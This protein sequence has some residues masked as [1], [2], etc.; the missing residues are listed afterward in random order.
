MPET[1]LLKPFRDRV[2]S[3]YALMEAMITQASIH[4]RELLKAR[5]QNITAD[6]AKDR[7]SLSW[8]VDSSRWDMLR[9]KGY[10]THYKTSEVTG[11]PRMYYDHSRPFEKDVRFYDYFTP[12]DL[13]QS[14]EAYVI[15]QGW[16][17]VIDLLALNGVKMKRLT[18]D[19]TISVEACR[20]ENYQSYPQAYEKHHKNTDV[21]ISVSTTRLPFLKGD[22]WIPTSQ[23]CR[24][25][26]TE[27]LEP[28]G[29]DSYFAW[30]FFDA[31]LEE[32]EGYSTYRWEDIAAAWLKQHPEIR[33]SLEKRKLSD[34]SFL[35]NADAQ[36]YFVYRHTP[37]YEPAHLRY[38]VF[39]VIQ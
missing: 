9:F 13:I 24:R 6:E 28:T 4:A 27:M 38:P 18:K 33:D 7:W 31:I 16:H 1:H 34:T 17:E 29:A 39:R 35:H 2:L 22:Y 11:L 12:G 20:I 5:Q 37:Y 32:K 26:I 10:Q 25:F 30:N 21:K 19:T 8:K 36:L 15:P 23:P 14:P 3:T